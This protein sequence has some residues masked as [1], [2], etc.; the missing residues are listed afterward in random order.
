MEKDIEAFFVEINFRKIKWLIIC[1]YNPN[2]NNIS[3][4]LDSITKGLTFYIGK[5][6]KVLLMGDF[7]VEISE[8][9]MKTFCETFNLNGLINIPTC[10]KNPQKPSTIDLFITNSPKSFIGTNVFETGLSDFHKLIVTV[11]KVTFEKV[12]PRIIHYRDY[13][14][15]NNSF[16]HHELGVEL[17]NHDIEKF[18]MENLQLVL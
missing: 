13:K 7:N 18:L 5:Y 6:D 11:L 1:C 4:Y 8:S 17:S 3:K 16:F 9:N 12:P 15:F 2:R 14:N 10:F